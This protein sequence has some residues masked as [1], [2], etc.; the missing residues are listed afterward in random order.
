MLVFI[1]FLFSSYIYIAR[2]IFNGYKY[3]ICSFFDSLLE[4]NNINKYLKT[5]EIIIYF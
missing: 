3:V 1:Y 5:K 4:T 2:V